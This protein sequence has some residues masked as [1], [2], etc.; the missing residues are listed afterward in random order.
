MLDVESL[1]QDRYPR[2]QVQ[3]ALIAKPLITAL[4][5]LLHE[6]ELRQL[7]ADSPHKK[8]FDFIEKVL[9]YFD[10][11]YRL[12]DG[13]AQRIPSSGKVVIIAN[14]PIG[15]LWMVWRY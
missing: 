3:Q 6:K 5:L 1:L 9:D 11:S 8:G 12:R 15:T 14:H 10:F 7:E 4:R 13:E 2:W